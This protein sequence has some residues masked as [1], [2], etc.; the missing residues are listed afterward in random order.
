MYTSLPCMETKLH[1][2]QVHVRCASLITL[3]SRY[4]QGF[5]VC[6]C[7]G[8]GDGARICKNTH[9]QVIYEHI[10]EIIEPPQVKS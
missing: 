4:R 5:C 10:Y 9:P 6:V 3:E 2:A 1:I 7:V 8:G